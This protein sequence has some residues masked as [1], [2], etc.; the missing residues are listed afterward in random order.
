MNT[1]RIWV[2]LVEDDVTS[3]TLLAGLMHK[4]GFEVICAEDGERAV[5]VIT[6]CRPDCILLDLKMPRMHG[7]AFLSLL[8]EKDRDLPVV[9]MSAVEKQPELV[10][11]IESLGI[12]GWLS[13]PVD[14]E[15][16]AV[17]IKEIIK[18]AEPLSDEE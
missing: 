12:Q 4:K 11:T 6:Y 1:K 8:R 13:K 15:D 16:A 17:K 14:P 18:P 3:R 10:A 5:D 9:I 7:H 2:L